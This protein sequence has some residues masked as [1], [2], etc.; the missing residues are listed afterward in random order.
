MRFVVGA[1]CSAVLGQV[2]NG[3]WLTTAIFAEITAIVVMGLVLL[4]GY[5]GQLS[6]GQGAFMMIGAYTS[7]YLTVKQGWPALPALPWA[8]C[9]RR[10]RRWR[11]AA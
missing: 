4:T 1:A 11:S 2:L 5:C 9:W 3:I 10:S 8:W 6:L 7:G